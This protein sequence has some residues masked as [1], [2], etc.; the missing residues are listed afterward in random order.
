MEAR[1]RAHTKHTQTRCI[2]PSICPTHLHDLMQRVVREGEA[3]KRPVI[4][5]S[6]P[7]AR[8][9]LAPQKRGAVGLCVG[10]GVGVGVDVWVWVLMCGCGC[11][12]IYW[13]VGG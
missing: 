8:L 10:V 1:Y 4:S 7:K 2:Y 6:G 11:V 13:D 12:F 9:L 3:R 5:G